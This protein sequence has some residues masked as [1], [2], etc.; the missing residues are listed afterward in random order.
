VRLWS[1][2]P[3]HLDSKGL[4]A[5]W[6][7][8]LLAL[9][10]LDGKTKGY[11]QHPQLARFKRCREPVAALRK[12]LS[13]VRDEARERG[14]RFDGSKLGR[15]S[16][17]ARVPVTRGQL[18]YEWRHLLRK[19]YRRDR[20]RWTKAKM[21]HATPHPMFDVVAGAIEHWEKPF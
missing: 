7:E 14:Y 3:K 1:L 16:S 20:A 17:R 8:G 18:D 5:L 11:R 15:V 2:H 6:R 9:A 19:L 12:Y 13:S 21:A 4:V 10:V